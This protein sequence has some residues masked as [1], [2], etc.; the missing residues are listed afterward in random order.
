MYDSAKGDFSLTVAGDCMLTQKISMHEEPGFKELVDVMRRADATFVNLETC[1]RNWDEGTPTITSGT[2]MTT[3]PQ[4]LDELKWLGVDIVAC[5]NNHA[6]DYGEGGIL[7]T[8]RHLDDAGVPHAGTGRNLAEARMPG[9]VETVGGRLGLVATTAAFRPWNQAGPQRSDIQG[10]PG[11]NPFNFKTT[12]TVDGETFDALSRMN[13]ELGFARAEE[14]NK[15]HFYS[16]KEVS[17]S[18]A[19][20]T[21]VFGKRV[22]RGNGFSITT[23]GD[24]TDMEETLRAVREAR[25]QADWVLVSFHCHEFNG[26]SLKTATAKVDLSELADIAAEFSHAAIDAGAD[27]VAGHGSHTPLGI[28]IY[29]GKPIFYSLGTFVFQNETI[30]FIPGDAYARFDLG[31]E[32]GPADFLDERTNSGQKGFP[33]YAGYWRSFVAECIFKD[34]RPARIVLHPIEEGFGQSRAQRGRP[35]IVDGELAKE[36]ISRVRALSTPFGTVIQFED[37]KGV[38]DLS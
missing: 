23:K 38:I 34:H 21:D 37:G 29:K 7:A 35:V 10:R 17:G 27:V 16:D 8:I 2:P 32:A 28:E 20:E 5:A 14:R 4:L 24:A 26:E 31:P 3:A 22:V 30:P 19:D 25:R 6:F 36:I 12:Y 1:V 13:E 33:A 18:T 9:Y 15:K 11:V